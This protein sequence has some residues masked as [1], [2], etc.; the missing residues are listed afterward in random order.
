MVPYCVGV[1]V[2]ESNVGSLSV[3]A[4]PSV[5]AAEVASP[6]MTATL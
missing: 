2:T 1:K 4:L 5:R 6:V 3:G